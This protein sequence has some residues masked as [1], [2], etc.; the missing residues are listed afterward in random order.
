LRAIRAI[1][2]VDGIAIGAAVNAKRV[3]NGVRVEAV[4]A[5]IAQVSAVRRVNLWRAALS[6]SYSEP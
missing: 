6:G 5:Q 4:A 3:G 1:R 2:I